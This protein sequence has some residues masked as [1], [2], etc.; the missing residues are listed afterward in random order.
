ML[1]VFTIPDMMCNNCVMHLEAMEDEL[2]GVKEARA[3]LSKHSL[4]VEYDEQIISPQE[5][6]E[7]VN[8]QGYSIK[9]IE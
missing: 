2:P 8:G 5:I 4:S 1:K 3:A 9:M 6:A 7:W